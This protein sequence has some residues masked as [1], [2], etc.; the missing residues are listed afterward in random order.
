MKVLLCIMVFLLLLF[1]K[2]TIGF[3]RCFFSLLPPLLSVFI[4]QRVIMVVYYMVVTAAL[5]MCVGMCMLCFSM[6]H[7]ILFCNMKLFSLPS[8]TNPLGLFLPSIPSLPL[9]TTHL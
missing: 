6:P 8:P 4:I 5:S 7:P 9:L 1:F 2:D 3:P